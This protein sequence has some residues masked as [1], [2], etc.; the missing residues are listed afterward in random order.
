[1]ATGP[2]STGEKLCASCGLCCNGVIFADVQLQRGDDAAQLR[3]LGLLKANNAKKFPQPCTMHDGCRCSIYK[4]RPRYCRE[5]ECLLFQN[6]KE[7]RVSEP[8]ANRVINDALKKA[9]RVRE[10]LNELGDTD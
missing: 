6:V 9:S 8:E 2:T 4:D 5:F 1:M 3:K 7:G 10:L